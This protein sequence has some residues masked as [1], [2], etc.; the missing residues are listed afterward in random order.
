MLLAGVCI[1]F[2]CFY[3]LQNKTNNFWQ[4]EIFNLQIHPQHLS[5]FIYNAGHGFYY[6][7]FLYE[8][9]RANQ[10]F[11]ISVI[12][13]LVSLP[14]LMLYYVF[15]TA[16]QKALFILSCFSVFTI[17]GYLCFMNPPVIPRYALPLTIAILFTLFVLLQDIQ[18]QLKYVLC[19]PW[20]ITGIIS[21]VNFKKYSF[22]P[23]E[24]K[25]MI[26]TV[27]YLEKQHLNYIFSTQGLLQWQ[28]MFYSEEKLQARFIYRTDRYPLYVHNVNTAYNNDPSKTAI[29]SF[30]QD[31]NKD[32]E[33]HCVK[34][35]GNG[36]SIYPSPSP[37]VLKIREY[38]F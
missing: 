25:A 18:T 5:G 27:S 33:R 28:L 7:Q 11:S 22:M 30:S 15:T 8:A 12:V 37:A 9:P 29:V 24:R 23:V 21:L 10:A 35:L 34:D 20:I 26:S 19:M 13:F 17:I 14:A 2:T 1:M 6:L 4:P 3:F 16:R 36:F 31:L 32:T 38:E